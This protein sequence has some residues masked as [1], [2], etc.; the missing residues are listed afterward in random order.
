MAQES[1]VMSVRLP[2]K[3][4]AEIVEFA[5]S[6]NESKGGAIRLLLEFG[7]KKKEILDIANLSMVGYNAR[8]TALEKLG[9]MLDR[10]IKEFRDIDADD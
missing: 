10:L 7:L 9:N 6:V 1:I 3:M 8:A 2:L 4:E 5:D